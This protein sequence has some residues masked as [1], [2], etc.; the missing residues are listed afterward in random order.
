MK[1]SKNLFLSC[2][3]LILLAGCTGK[4]QEASITPTTIPEANTSPV[5]TSTDAPS[6]E[7]KPA[8][9]T[10]LPTTAV[11]SPVP[12]TETP[13]PSATLNLEI[14]SPS[15]EP[16]SPTPTIL[17]PTKE[18][19]LAKTPTEIPSQTTTTN[20]P[21]KKP[22]PLPTKPPAKVSPVPTPTPAT[23]PLQEAELGYY[24]DAWLPSVELSE[25]N[26]PD[27]GFRT[28]LSE[29]VDQDK[30]GI[31]T[32]A[33][34]ETLVYLRD[35]CYDE[36]I[37]SFYP[38]DPYDDRMMRLLYNTL[39]FTGIEYFP[40]L[41][42]IYLDR[43]G[44]SKQ[45]LYPTITIKNLPNLKEFYFCTL[46]SVSES[47]CHFTFEHLPQ[48][49]TI[50]IEINN[51]DA[52]SSVTV[53]NTRR[54]KNFWL[55]GNITG[56]NGL[57]Q[58]NVQNIALG[59]EKQIYNIPF[60]SNDVAE[61]TVD[62]TKFSRLKEFHFRTNKPCESY[63]FTGQ[64]NLTI[65]AAIL[66]GGAAILRNMPAVCDARILGADTMQSENCP[67]LTCLRIG[68]EEEATETPM[69]ILDL[70]SFRNLKIL[71]IDWGIMGI[72]T[73]L[74]PNDN[75]DILRDYSNTETMISY[76]EQPLFNQMQQN[77]ENASSNPVTLSGTAITYQSVSAK[78]LSKPGIY[79]M[80]C[81]PEQG[82]RIDLDGNGI[83]EELY[84]DAQDFYLNGV[85]LGI[86]RMDYTGNGTPWERF[87]IQVL[88]ED[89][90]K[91]QL[92]INTA[93][94]GRSYS[95]IYY[96]AEEPLQYYWKG[97]MFHNWKE[98][99]NFQSIVLN[100]YIGQYL[101]SYDGTLH[102][103]AYAEGNNNTDTT[104]YP[105]TEPIYT[106]EGISFSD[107]K[108]KWILLY[109]SGEIPSFYFRNISYK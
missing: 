17:T 21:T 107:I 7:V 12:A 36:K 85:G 65:F 4:H 24:K 62:L 68:R 58:T 19:S 35:T 53:K 10:P 25:E 39:D 14:P 40:Q 86:S 26:F 82:Y 102:L 59:P 75:I 50:H 72:K 45:P 94:L 80:I 33:E 105:F 98:E 84:T 52:S 6:S 11:T 46:N 95:S 9:S 91:Y 100:D 70:T 8:T 1:K 76:E 5:V 87:W 69:E 63:I 20:T 47:N 51:P 79:E 18:L 104:C 30:D 16:I 27:E 38:D 54:L 74:L 93:P 42:T 109:G 64:T 3:L 37:E 81:T 96:N 32:L 73:L 44:K 34:R 92:I 48:L 56:L 2:T 55:S 88:E 41:K 29:L 67:N 60:I 57:E 97:G 49:Q 103:Q 31:L 101:L 106:K 108:G 13:M 71:D 78:F 61:I 66:P 22:T 77:I 99:L 89:N 23:F 90:P 15:L 83:E 28:L 43:A